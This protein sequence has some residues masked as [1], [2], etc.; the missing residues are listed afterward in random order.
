MERRALQP[1]EFRLGRTLRLSR[2]PSD[3]FLRRLGNAIAWVLDAANML[4]AYDAR[5]LGN[6]LYNS[7]QNAARDAMGRYVKFTVPMVANGKVYA[8]TQ[9]SLV[10]YGLLPGAAAPLAVTNAASAQRGRAAPGS[11][12]SIYG[13][14]FSPDATSV[15]INGVAAPLLYAGATQ[16]NLQV[17]FESCLRER[18]GGRECR[19]PPAGIRG[20]HCRRRRTRIVHA[21][22]GSRGRPQ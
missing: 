20:H 15:S 17:P 19:W 10:V 16:I 12:L 7:N 8:G 11:L 21:R 3:H 1:A 13:S 5:N 22:S 4:H 6:E 2:M 18:Q 14:G 9:N